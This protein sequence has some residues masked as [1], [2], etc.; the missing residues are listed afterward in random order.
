LIIQNKNQN[1]NYL[2]R[3]LLIFQISL[4]LIILSKAFP[5]GMESKL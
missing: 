2:Q 5:Q 3:P 4:S 1:M